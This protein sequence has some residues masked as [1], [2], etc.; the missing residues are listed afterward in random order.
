[1]K[2]IWVFD[3]DGTIQ[4]DSDAKAISIEKMQEKLGLL[5]GMENILSS[6]KSIRTMPA[7]CGLPTGAMN[8]YELTAQGWQLLSNGIRGM[9]GFKRLDKRK[10]LA[11]TEPNVGEILDILTSSRP[12][13]IRELVGHAV[14]VYNSGD[15][16][17]K[18]YRPSR[19]N[20]E[21]RVDDGD[22]TIAS[23]WF[24]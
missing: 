14:R 3:F 12:Q 4:C 13:Y 19:F 7:M 20:V 22:R 1:M 23:V 21:M 17:T 15:A 8:T 9:Q 11:E 6:E 18:D 10:N 5:V 2:N 24:G 16:I